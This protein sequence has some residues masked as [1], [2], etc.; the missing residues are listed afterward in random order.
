MSNNN[1][2]IPGGAEYRAKV[3]S[4]LGQISGESDG[5]SEIIPGGAAFRAKVIS[6]L[7]SIA[8]SGGGGGSGGGGSS[9]VIIADT[10]TVAGTVIDEYTVDYSLMPAADYTDPSMYIN[11]MLRAEV[12]RDGVVSVLTGQVST[13]ESEGATLIGAMIGPDCFSDPVGAIELSDGAITF[14][15]FSS[16]ADEL[17][18]KLEVVPSASLLVQANPNTGTLSA[19]WQEIYNALI[20]QGTPVLIDGRSVSRIYYDFEGSPDK[21]F[22]ETIHVQGGGATSLVYGASASDDYPVYRGN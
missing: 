2:I 18:I 19:T 20:V 17:T 6:L 4:L 14:H 5:G 8:E 7:S 15:S 3:V 9:E 13:A 10:Q 11:K 21:Y 22:V 12:T 1:E 16:T